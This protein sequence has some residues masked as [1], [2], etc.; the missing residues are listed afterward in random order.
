MGAYSVS[1]RPITAFSITSSPIIYRTKALAY[2]TILPSKLLVFHRVLTD[3]KKRQKLHFS[4]KSFK[5]NSFPDVFVCNITTILSSGSY[6]LMQLFKYYKTM[7]FSKIRNTDHCG[8][9]HAK[10]SI[11]CIFSHCLAILNCK[12]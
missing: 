7:P 3:F 6:H 12:N 11:L 9:N 1:S 2:V 10:R 8:E 4:N 5:N